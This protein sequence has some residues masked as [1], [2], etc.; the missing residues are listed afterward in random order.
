MKKLILIYTIFSISII[1]F[2]DLFLEVDYITKSILRILFFV[3]IPVIYIIDNEN[4]NLIDYFKVSKLS[5]LKYGLFYG[6]LSFLFI[7]IAYYLLKDFLDM[8]SLIETANKYNVDKTNIIYIS[9]YLCIINAFQE[10]FFFRGFIFKTLNDEGETKLGYL[11]S[12]LTFSIY[13][14]GVIMAWFNIFLLIVAI[15]A[16]SLFASLL[17]Y[18]NTKTD[19]FLNSYIV[20]IF[21]DISIMIIAYQFVNEYL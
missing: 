18:I 13:H 14:L 8:N 12:S 19:G 3:V 20:H 10:E 1:M 16:M 6:L 21:I 17:N 2:V 9:L 11:L 15:L 5:T 7:L 4:I